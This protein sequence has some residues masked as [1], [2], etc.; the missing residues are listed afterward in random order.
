MSK[1]TGRVRE[2][3]INEQISYNRPSKLQEIT[4]DSTQKEI[5]ITYN[6]LAKLSITNER[7]SFQ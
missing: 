2:I 3:L 5:N 4:L 7:S 1:R 6:K